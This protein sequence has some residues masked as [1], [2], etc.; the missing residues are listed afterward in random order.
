LSAR[1]IKDAN[2]FKRVLI[3]IDKTQINE[4]IIMLVQEKLLDD[5]VFEKLRETPI[6]KFKDAP[7]G[8][9]VS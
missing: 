3:E 5:S 4:E 8:E 1:K 9:I 6:E 7:D 2:E